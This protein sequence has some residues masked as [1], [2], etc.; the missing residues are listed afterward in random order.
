[1]GTT[2]AR[3]TNGASPWVRDVLN[4]SDSDLSKPRAGAYRNGEFIVPRLVA[5]KRSR[6]F[7][8]AALGAIVHDAKCRVIGCF[9]APKSCAWPPGAADR[10]PPPFEQWLDGVL[11]PPRSWAKTGL[12]EGWWPQL[13]CE[14]CATP[15]HRDDPRIPYKLA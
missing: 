15:A 13:F 14:P 4:V 9:G 6:A 2:T 7:Y 1:M 8:A 5:R 12:I 3:R 10:L 11:C